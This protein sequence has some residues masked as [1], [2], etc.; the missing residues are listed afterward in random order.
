[1]KKTFPLHAV[2][3]MR[4]KKLMGDFAKAHELAEWVL[5][6]P[7]WTHEMHLF[8]KK[9]SDKLGEQ[10]PGLPSTLPDVNKNNYAEALAELEKVHGTS[11]E[12]EQGNE[13]RTESPL[14]TLL[15]MVDKKKVTAVL[16]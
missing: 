16:V 3:T 7:I 4:T 14:D 12:V 5:G 2:L 15:G 9:I 6:H 1:M 10:F 11:F 8:L 13:E